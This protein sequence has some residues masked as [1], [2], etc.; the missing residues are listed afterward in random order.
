MSPLHIRKHSVFEGK[1]KNEEKKKQIHKMA[2]RQC[3]NALSI[4]VVSKYILAQI[5]ARICLPVFLFFLLFVAGLG[6]R[7]VGWCSA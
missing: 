3:Q 4:I 2:P 1:L 5:P 7:V 6:S